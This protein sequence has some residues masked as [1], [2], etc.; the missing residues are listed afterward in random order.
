MSQIFWSQF[1]HF[2]YFNFVIF[3]RLPHRLIFAVL[4]RDSILL[5]NSQCNSP[6][7]YMENLH[8]DKLSSISWTPDGRILV[9]SSLEG[10]NSFIR[11][12]TKLLGTPCD[13]QPDFLAL[14]QQQKQ[15]QQQQIEAQSQSK[16]NQIYPKGKIGS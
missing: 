2:K 10:F 8:Y 1:S 14:Q 4:C 11:M 16:S 15:E 5:Y 6:F 13:L 7:A 12:D 3:S 9:V